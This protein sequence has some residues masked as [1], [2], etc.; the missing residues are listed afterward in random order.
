MNL[1]SSAAP[2]ISALCFLGYGTACLTT[3]RMRSEFLR[4]GLPHLRIL[5]ALLQLAAGCGLLIGYRYPVC[6]VFAAAGLSFMMLVAVAVRVRIKDPPSGFFQALACLL[7]NVFVL[8][9][10]LL[11]LAERG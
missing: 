7:L 10:S 5:T 11:R 8:R 3:Q 9:E 6:A 4:F 2:A 1:L